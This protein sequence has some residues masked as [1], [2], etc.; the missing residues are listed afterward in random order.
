MPSVLESE[1]RVSESMSSPLLYSPAPSLDTH[2]HT[3]THYRS[4]CQCHQPMMPLLI[5]WLRP[6]RSNYHETD[7]VL[8]H[9]R[10]H[11]PLPPPLPTHSHRSTRQKRLIVRP[12]VAITCRSC[13]DRGA[14]GCFSV[15]LRNGQMFAFNSSSASSLLPLLLSI[16]FCNT[17]TLLLLIMTII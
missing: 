13:T 6:S 2:T 14:C 8:P 1:A 3:H 7:A 15:H 17:T 9:L 4:R 10:T 5:L 11:T 16:L 12:L